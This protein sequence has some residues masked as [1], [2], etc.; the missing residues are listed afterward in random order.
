MAPRSHVIWKANPGK[1]RLQLQIMSR[2]MIGSVV[3]NELHYRWD[4][5]EFMSP[6][7][8]IKVR[9][10]DSRWCHWNCLLT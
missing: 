6:Y 8:A 2:E 3:N 9:G 4:I 1:C 10:F 5:G 7:I